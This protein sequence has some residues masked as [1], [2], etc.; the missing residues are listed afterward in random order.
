[1]AQPP[2]QPQQPQQPPQLP[3]ASDLGFLS[4]DVTM[5]T[6]ISKVDRLQ[7]GLSWVQEQLPGILSPNAP[8]T[9]QG[10]RNLNGLDRSKLA[11]A[12]PTR[13]ANLPG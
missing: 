11:Y 7:T 5:E 13:F 6:L 9:E 1:M 2:Q 3:A 10:S 8:S 4:T 12:R